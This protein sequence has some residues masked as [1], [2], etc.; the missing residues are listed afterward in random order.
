MSGWL[1]AALILLLIAAFL[2]IRLRLSAAYD[3]E[4]IQIAACFG[5]I[6]V[7]RYPGRSGGKKA[8]R[9][10]KPKEPETEE[11]P[12]EPEKKSAGGKLPPL[13]DLLSII[14][15]TLGKL[16][17]KLRVDELTLWYC[18]ASQDPF[19]AA[20][21]FG[22]ASAAVELILAPLERAFRVKKRDIRTA[23]SFTETEPTVVMRLSLS[24]SIFSLVCVALY[25]GLRY[26]ISM[27]KQKKL[28][29]HPQDGHRY[30]NTEG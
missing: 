18:S 19:A 28:T 8:P 7:F 1:W 29:G 6:T 30:N 15:D 2:S 10:K 26:L 11:E 21:A 16:R 14:G 20:M 4:G 17:R 24:L 13:R 27:R 12:E 23:V 5:R 22:G 25:A 9:K 3:A